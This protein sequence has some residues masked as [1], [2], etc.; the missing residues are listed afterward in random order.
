MAKIR[1]NSETTNKFLR[2]AAIYNLLK[3]DQGF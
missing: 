2:T 1:G 3:A